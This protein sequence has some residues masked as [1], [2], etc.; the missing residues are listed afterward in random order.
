MIDAS[1]VGPGGCIGISYIEKYREKAE[2]ADFLLFYTG[3]DK[4]WGL[5]GYMRDFPVISAV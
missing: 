4:V 5:D 2:K 3:W 1:G